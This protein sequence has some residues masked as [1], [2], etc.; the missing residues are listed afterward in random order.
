MKPKTIRCA[1][2]VTAEPPA[3]MARIKYARSLAVFGWRVEIDGV[4]VV[5]AKCDRCASKQESRAA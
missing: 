1:C 3:G 4:K 5:S 2:G